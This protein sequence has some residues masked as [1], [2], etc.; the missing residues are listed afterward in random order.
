MKNSMIRWA[1]T[2]IVGL[3]LAVGSVAVAAAQEAGA[4]PEYPLKKPVH[5]S[6]SFGGIFGQYDQAQLQR[7]YKV[8]KEVCSACHSMRLIKFRNLADEGGP[9]F[10]DEQVKSL[11]AEYT[12]QDGPDDNGEMFDRPRL[13]KD[14]FP[15]PFAN[16]KAARAASGAALPPDMSLLA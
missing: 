3:G 10:S 2:A 16:D 11:A 4:T 8:Y 6:W 7:G 1:S 12:I 14:P 15:S 9:H 13:P 5:Q